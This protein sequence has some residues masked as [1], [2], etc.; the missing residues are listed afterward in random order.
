LDVDLRP[1]F[2]EIDG[3]RKVAINFVAKIIIVVGDPKSVMPG[4]IPMKQ[5]QQ[6][7]STWHGDMVKARERIQ[8][9][10]R[11]LGAFD[12]YFALLVCGLCSR[13][14]LP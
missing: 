9:L 7:Q 12:S 5:Q 11:V 8:A 3:V 4:E 6:Q 14:M 2:C 10:N 1:P 13:P